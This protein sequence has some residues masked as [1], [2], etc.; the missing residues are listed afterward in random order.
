M[1]SNTKSV[2]YRNSRGTSDL[3]KLLLL[4]RRF[5][6]EAGVRR[7]TIESKGITE[8]VSERTRPIPADPKAKCSRGGRYNL[9]SDIL[10][11]LPKVGTC[12][13]SK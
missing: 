1:S 9:S 5:L 3:D 10:F 11:Y 8:N 12:A 7:F 2:R 4:A 6:D 13:S